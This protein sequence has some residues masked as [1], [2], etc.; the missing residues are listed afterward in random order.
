MSGPA[1]TLFE[2]SDQLTGEKFL[3][4]TGASISLLATEA[5]QLEATS[6]VCLTSVDGSK[7]ISG[8]FEP[9][10]IRFGNTDYGWKFLKAAVPRNILGADFLAGNAL[11]VDMATKSLV[12]PYWHSVSQL[13]SIRTQQRVVVNATFSDRFA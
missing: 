7:V 5:G 11:V 9:R 6:P 2:I 4:D 10:T 1:S 12:S 8:N 13:A 3:V